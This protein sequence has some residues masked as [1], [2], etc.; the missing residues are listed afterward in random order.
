MV[1]RL[2]DKF[3][4]IHM[5]NIS[6]DMLEKRI[7]DGIAAARLKRQSIRQVAPLAPSSPIKATSVP[8]EATPPPPPP[9][10]PSE[11]T[12]HHTY[13]HDLPSSLTATIFSSYIISI[14][15]KHH[16]AFSCLLTYWTISSSVKNGFRLFDSH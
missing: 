4:Q 14:S 9:Q 1:H 3:N 7:R 2:V 8:D 11:V 15:Y 13:L 6:G 5:Q 12:L 10:F 16:L